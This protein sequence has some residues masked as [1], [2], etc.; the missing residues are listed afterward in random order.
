MA[1]FILF[2]PLLFTLQTAIAQGMGGM[3][4]PREAVLPDVDKETLILQQPS[5]WYPYHR[6]TDAKVDTFMFPTGQEPQDWEEALQTERFLTTL[7]VTSARQVYEF[8][9]QGSSCAEH[10]VRLTKEAQENGY[11]MAQWMENCTRADGAEL[12]TMVKTIVGNEQL[13]VINKIWKYSINDSEI[14]EWGRYLDSVYVCDPTIEGN[15]HP[16]RP[17]NGPPGGARPQR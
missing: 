8:R 11:S 13:Y 2:L 4:A 7:G 1:R 12:V 15:A 17:P 6:T 5:K 10:S 16:C 14:E 9:T 3:A